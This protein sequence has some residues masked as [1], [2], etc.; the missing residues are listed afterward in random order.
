MDRDIQLLLEKYV[1]VW[2]HVELYRYLFEAMVFFH[3]CS[4]RS[5]QELWPN[6]EINILVYGPVR[7]EISSSCRTMY[8]YFFCQLIFSWMISIR[9]SQPNTLGCRSIRP[10]MLLSIVSK[11]STHACRGVICS[12]KNG[13]WRFGIIML[14]GSSNLFS[15]ET[16]SLLRDSVEGSIQISFHINNVHFCEKKKEKIERIKYFNYLS[17]IWR[18]WYSGQTAYMV[19]NSREVETST[20]RFRY[21]LL[22]EYLMLWLSLTIPT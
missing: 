10:R 17:V 15:R 14:L 7:I 1:I 11:F 3:F 2:Y 6:S 4:L 13:S 8:R 5:V 21:V 9:G 22:L 16:G 12:L 20:F 19:D 18:N